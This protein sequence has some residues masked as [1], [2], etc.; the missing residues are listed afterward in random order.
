M[1]SKNLKTVE[2]AT[3][4]GVIMLQ[5]PEHITHLLQPLDEAVFKLL[6]GYYNQGKMDMGAFWIS[7]NAISRSMDSCRGLFIGSFRKCDNAR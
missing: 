5:L 3:E 7:S 2:L 6:E 4:N 1:Y